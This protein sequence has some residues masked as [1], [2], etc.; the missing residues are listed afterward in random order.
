MVRRAVA[1]RGLYGLFV[2]MKYERGDWIV[3]M[4]RRSR[5]AMVERGWKGGDGGD[6]SNGGGGIEGCMSM[7]APFSGWMN[8]WVLLGMWV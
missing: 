6:D 2:K 8:G 3:V 5:G 4:L 1:A 7:Y